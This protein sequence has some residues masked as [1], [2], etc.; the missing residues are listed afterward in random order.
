MYYVWNP[1]IPIV[2]PANRRNRCTYLRVYN[3]SR[4]SP[5]NAELE[6]FI[7][8][9]KWY[10]PPVKLY[11][12]PRKD[13]IPKRLLLP[14]SPF[15]ELLQSGAHC[16]MVSKTS[17][18]QTPQ[19]CRHRMLGTFIVCYRI[20]RY[21][22]INHTS[23]IIYI[24][25]TSYVILHTPYFYIIHRV[26]TYAITLDHVPSCSF[27]YVF[28]IHIFGNSS[29]QDIHK[30]LH[31][32]VSVSIHRWSDHSPARRWHSWHDWRR[33]TV[34]L[35]TTAFPEWLTIL[36]LKSDVPEIRR[37]FSACKSS[38]SLQLTKSVGDSLESLDQERQTE[39]ASTHPALL[40]S[41]PSVA[42]LAP[43]LRF[44]KDI[45]VRPA[46]LMY[47]LLLFALFAVTQCHNPSHP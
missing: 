26:Q 6:I 31:N 36:R 11:R 13:T 17:H 21:I 32:S 40:C 45:H 34:P 33:A 20:S 8:G 22:I 7:P 39:C 38:S 44:C 16:C 27:I 12:S 4:R 19:N 5:S 2:D 25:Q 43:W 10:L 18:I 37:C 42:Q 24:H 41:P 29:I 46:A 47:V 9:S 28:C 23:H 15:L 35:T 3:S 14:N 1:L 30:F